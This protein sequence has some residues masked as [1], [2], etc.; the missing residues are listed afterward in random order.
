MEN[1]IQFRQM[2]QANSD[3]EKTRYQQIMERAEMLEQRALYYAELSKQFKQASE[4]D[5]KLA[6]G[7][8]FDHS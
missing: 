1:V 4:E 7:L 8:T 3:K 5:K 2:K 6:K